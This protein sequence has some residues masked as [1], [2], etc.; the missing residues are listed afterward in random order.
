MLRSES[1]SSHHCKLCSPL[2]CDGDAV[3]GI[4]VNFT[5]AL[6]LN[7]GGS[8]VLAIHNNCKQSE[9]SDRKAHSDGRVWGSL[10]AFNVFR[11]TCD[12]SLLISAHLHLVVVHLE[13]E[14]SH[15]SAI[16]PSAQCTVEQKCSMS[17]DRGAY[18]H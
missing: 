10:Q 13:A 5:E 16:A 14:R 11:P 3:T 2:N 7:Q 6:C 15:E 4:L 12:A 17:S 8:R 9:V 18:A 1:C